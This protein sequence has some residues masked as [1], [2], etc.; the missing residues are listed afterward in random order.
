MS[1]LLHAYQCRLILRFHCW[2][3]SKVGKLVQSPF[4]SKVIAGT[5]KNSCKYRME[6]KNNYTEELIKVAEGPS[7]CQ[8]FNPI[9]FLQLNNHQT[10][11]NK[12]WDNSTDNSEK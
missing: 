4:V 3:R 9:D 11:N 7:K 6:V 2:G 5:T 8:S 1:N 12:C 10:S